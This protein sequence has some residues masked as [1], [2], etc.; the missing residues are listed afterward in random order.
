MITKGNG[1]V[2]QDS[3]TNVPGLTSS[4][5]SEDTSSDEDPKVNYVKNVK[6]AKKSHR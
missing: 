3:G 6:F 5:D 2:H 4:S 1:G